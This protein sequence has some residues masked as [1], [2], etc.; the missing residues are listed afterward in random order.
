MQDS[1][2]Q[3]IIPNIADK[4]SFSS[5]PTNFQWKFNLTE[6]KLSPAIKY[7]PQFYNIMNS[8][9]FQLGVDFEDNTLRIILV[10]YRG[11]Y[12]SD[13]SCGLKTT[14][15]FYFQINVFGKRGKRKEFSFKNNTDYSISKFML[16]SNG[17]SH[18]VNITEIEDLTIDGFIHFNCFFSKI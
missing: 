8:Y 14:E 9:C 4:E 1:H 13:I 18:I 5:I 17:W 6:I 12:D 7:T 16:K 3:M 10:R 11:K 2:K 15:E